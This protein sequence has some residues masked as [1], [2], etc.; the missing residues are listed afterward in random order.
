MNFSQGP[1]A[2]PKFQVSK[3]RSTVVT[4][5]EVTL[6]ET[7]S[8]HQLVKAIHLDA[9]LTKFQ[10]DD[11]AVQVN[12]VEIIA[13]PVHAAPSGYRGRVS[14]GNWERYGALGGPEAQRSSSSG[15]ARKQQGRRR[16][17]RSILS[18]G[19]EG[20]SSPIDP[21]DRMFLQLAAQ[22][23]PDLELLALEKAWDFDQL[24]AAGITRRDEPEAGPGTLSRTCRCTIVIENG[25]R[26]GCNL[27]N[28]DTRSCS[29]FNAVSSGH[30]NERCPSRSVITDGDNSSSPLAVSQNFSRQ[31]EQAHVPLKKVFQET[32]GRQPQAEEVDEL[33]EQAKRCFSHST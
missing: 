9:L 4:S 17:V 31:A 13:E 3:G 24:T 8:E 16:L 25:W 29:N 21:P 18:D 26:C 20:G 14:G 33:V 22:I 10:Q 27:N 30:N 6:T 15:N 12:R 2:I 32:A 19:L 1:L 7:Q 5:S 11:E 23:C 28:S